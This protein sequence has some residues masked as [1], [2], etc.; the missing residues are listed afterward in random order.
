MP[1]RSVQLL[2]QGLALSRQLL[3]LLRESRWDEAHA[4]QAERF[5]LIQAG[6]TLA[7]EQDVQEKI[8]LLRMIA[9]LDKEMAAIG[10]EGKAQLS[11][12]LRRLGQGR[13]AGKAYR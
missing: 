9:A 4:L 6:V 11:D 10:L 3:A 5:R 2:Q 7:R 1:R 8:T 13:R 12:Q